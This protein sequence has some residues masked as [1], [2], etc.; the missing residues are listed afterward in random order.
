MIFINLFGTGCAYF[1]GCLK[2]LFVK[3][4]CAKSELTKRKSSGI[5]KYPDLIIYGSE[6]NVPKMT[7]PM[8]KHGEIF[9]VDGTSLQFLT[10]ITPAHTRKH[11][12]FLLLDPTYSVEEQTDHVLYS[13]FTEEKVNKYGYFHQFKGLMDENV[14]EIDEKTPGILGNMDKHLQAVREKV[15][16]KVLGDD[17]FVMADADEI[18]AS[19]FDGGPKDSGPGTTSMNAGDFSNRGNNSRS[20]CNTQT[21]TSCKTTKKVDDVVTVVE[22]NNNNPVQSKKVT[23]PRQCLFTGDTLFCGGH[24]ALFEGTN[25]DMVRNFCL[26][27]HAVS[28]DTLLFPGHEYTNVLLE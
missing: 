11:C 2:F 15:R 22:V 1:T 7:R 9:T 12:M 6:P 20:N 18:V 25:Y 19:R 21:V 5:L 16:K 8:L 4:S 23:V 24:G 26:M 17:Y 10:L 14:A 13:R 3:L 28:I 27:L